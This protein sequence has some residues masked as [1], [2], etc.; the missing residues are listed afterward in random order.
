MPACGLYPALK[1]PKDLTA[2]ATDSDEVTTTWV[3]PVPVSDPVDFYELTR[4]T[5]AAFT[6]DVTVFDT[7]GEADPLLTTFVDSG[8]TSGITYFYKV[9]AHNVNG[10]GPFSNTDSATPGGVVAIMDITV[11]DIVMSAKPPKKVKDIRATADVQ[12]DSDGSPIEGASVRIDW[13]LDIGD[14][15]GPSFFLQEVAS[16]G[17]NGLVQFQISNAPD[18]I[19]TA[20]TVEVIPPT[21]F[22]WDL[23]LTASSNSIEK[24]PP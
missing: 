10:L 4:A 20:V 21:G 23:A 15:E 1:A 16:T 3:A 6:L 18:G 22:T 12:L 24:P 7:S 8:L 17:A 5:D 9:R 14:G 13:L 2:I 11:D 19:W